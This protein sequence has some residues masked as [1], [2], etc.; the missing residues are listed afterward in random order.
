[1]RIKIA[2]MR[3]QFVIL[4]AVGIVQGSGEYR[5][6]LCTTWG[7]WTISIGLGKPLW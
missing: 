2:Y 6:Y 3:G 5:C 4:P 1:M 7:F